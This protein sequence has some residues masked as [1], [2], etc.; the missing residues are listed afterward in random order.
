MYGRNQHNIV[1]MLQLKINKLREK[2][3]ASPATL[4]NIV[5]QHPP[6]T[7]QC[8]SPLSYMHSI[9]HHVTWY[10]FTCYLTMGK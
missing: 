9:Y 6:A 5:I 3:K 1:I 7:S 4:F 10:I 2:N 8:S